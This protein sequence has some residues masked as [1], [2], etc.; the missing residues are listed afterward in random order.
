M[1]TATVNGVELE[2][3]E[4]GAGEP[5]LMIHG[6]LVAETFAPLL[7]E[8][9]LDRYRRIRYHRR[10]Y[11]ASERPGRLTNF[12][13]QA[14]DAA[15]LLRHLGIETAHVAGHSYGGLT[16]LRLALDTP[17]LVRSLVLLEPPM[18]ATALGHD[19][20]AGPLGPVLAAYRRGARAEAADLFCQA[21]AGPNAVQGLVSLLGAGAQAQARRDAETVFG[22]EFPEME[23]GL[24]TEA[25]AS[26]IR[27]PA[28][29]IVGQESHE[30]F[31]GSHAML[32]KWL[33]DVEAAVIPRATHFL[34]VEEPRAVAEAMARF[35][36][37]HPLS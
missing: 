22:T 30:L 1:K 16:A 12:H 20:F 13:E 23:K 34:Q 29:S 28:L 35:V 14:A 33:P 26:R 6:A 10:G 37:K 3:D 36:A 32:M 18:L 7:K 2:Y 5:I 31:R 11:A 4:V 19:F 25:D 9:A 15:A 24:F 8:P 21:V 17:S 27:L